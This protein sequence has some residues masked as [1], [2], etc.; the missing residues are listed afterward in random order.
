MLGPYV[1]LQT[2][3]E[4]EFAKV[5]LGMH[6][7]TGEEAAIKLIRKENVDSSTR[8]A[9]IKREI[10]V[11]RSVRHPNVVRLF[12]VIETEKYIG[13]VM[14]YAS[15]GEL[16]DHILA[17]RY[18]K[19]RDAGRLFAQLI[20]GV[21][22]MHS[23]NI[24]H[25]DLKLENLLLD[26]NRDVII[27][28]FGFANQFDISQGDLMATSCGSPCY[29]AP[30][31]VVSEGMYVGTAVDIWS[32]GV[33]LYAMLAGYLPYD[34]DPANPDGDNINL[35]YKY[36]LA[37]SLVFPDY[38]SPD[39]RDLLRKMLVPDPRRRCT[40]DVIKKHRWLAAYAHIFEETH[41]DDIEAL[42]SVMVDPATHAPAQISYQHP[43]ASATHLA[44]IPAA[45]LAPPSTSN[46]KR[47]TIQL[48][49]NNNPMEMEPLKHPTRPTKTRPTTM[50]P[51]TRMAEEDDVIAD[52]PHSNNSRSERHRS[53]T[54]DNASIHST[55]SR[56]NDSDSGRERRSNLT[57]M[58]FDRRSGSN[59]SSVPGKP[60]PRG[61]HPRRSSPTNILPGHDV[62]LR[63]HGGAIDEGALTSRPPKEVV[64]EIRAIILE[65]GLEILRESE[66]KF[67]CV[68]PS[69]HAPKRTT[70]TATSSATQ[71]T[72][73]QPVYGEPSIDAG[74]EVRFVVEICKIKNLTNLYIVDIRRMKGNIWSY[75]FIYHNLLE[76][77]D[78]KSKGFMNV[79]GDGTLA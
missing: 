67:K 23:K 6:V 62:K 36:I 54:A 55:G 31:L 50:M 47:H 77:L 75:K 20:S 33:I 38:I 34:D 39:A 29:A 14:E 60:I 35:L 46:P 66:F 26:R 59:S 74:D 8:L 53:I 9:K 2:V 57:S 27:T 58:L 44:S 11:L 19:E 51:Y 15:G 37:T 63:T 30:E 69:R 68:R 61:E 41:G 79:Q 42:P 56:G 71:T 65:M 32:C 24:V 70:T 13:I 21:S 45:S 1:M 16:F 3:G 43:P 7:D 48:E 17:H 4:G 64:T 5:K 10:M 52:L 25:R 78:L 76:R 28:D 22:Y 49:Y 72:V 12:D 40:M 18:L 73:V